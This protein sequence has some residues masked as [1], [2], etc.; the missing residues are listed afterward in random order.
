MRKGLRAQLA[1][2]LWLLG[3]QWQV[4][5]LTGEDAGSP[6]AA[7]LWF[8]HDPMTAL[9]R[10]GAGG[11]VDASGGTDGGATVRSYDPGDDPPLETLV[12]Q[13]PVLTDDDRRPNRETAVEAGRY[14]LSLLDEEGFEVD[15]RAPRAADVPDLLIGP[16]DREVDGEGDRYMTVVEGR[17]LDGAAL[18]EQL[19][20]EPT[21]SDAADWTGVS[22]GSV[23]VPSVGSGSDPFRRA[24]KAFVDW[25]ADLYDEPDG[26]AET[27][28]NADRMEYEF[29]VATGSGDGETVFAV[30]EYGGGRLDWEAFSTV[31]DTDAS[32][33]DDL[34]GPAVTGDA[35]D[36]DLP[37]TGAAGEVP[38]DLS[39]DIEG[40]EPDLA[41][42]PTR[43]SFPGM[44]SARWWELEDGSVNIGNMTVGPGEL[45]KLLLTEHATLYGNDWF[46]IPV[47]VPVGSLTRITE[48]LVTDTFGQVTSVG[49][50]VDTED[51]TSADATDVADETAEGPTAGALAD[52]G[53]WNMFMHAGLPNHD[54]PGMLLPP[55][56]GAHHESDPV[57]RVVLARDEL[58]NMAFGIELVTEDAIGDPLEWGEFARPTLA[59]DTVRG[60][61]DPAQERLRLTNPGGRPLDVGG[62]TVANGLGDSYAIPGGT[63]VGPDEHLTIHSG[64]GADVVTGELYWGRTSQPVWQDAEEV[65]VTDADDDLVLRAFIGEPVNPSLPDYRLVTD[66]HE[67]WFPMRMVPAG[68][69]SPGEFAIGDLRFD[70]ARLLDADAESHRPAGRVLGED[71]LLHDEELTRAGL[72]VTRGYQYAR[73]SGGDVH[74]WSG[75][76][77]ATGR[78]EGTSG[79]Q[80]DVL[81]EPSPDQASG[82]E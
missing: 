47:E 11:A 2:P 22:W 45:G 73:W 60:A 79:L 55:S 35:F 82:D 20:S 16:P 51:V 63:V 44:P 75:R 12:E 50:A 69:R 65:T 10:S 42:V 19:T 53:G 26:D 13:E 30:D 39:A 67:H 74:L 71:P 64:P 70:L 6:V 80:F 76:R 38:P 72:E 18:Y 68:E 61:D 9:D 41:T 36:L 78:G 52:S 21:M 17:S 5:E 1:D 27:A 49:P 59:V 46:S 62:W 77:A 3:R 24:A 7:E 43:V 54:E 31:Q 23:D 4:G 57:E 40:S 32:L 25:Y 8:E 56:L 66:V 58:A 37:G 28:W 14:F 34:D 81:E 29:R 15:G 33:T 48:F